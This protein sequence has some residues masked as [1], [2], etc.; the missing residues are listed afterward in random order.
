MRQQIHVYTED[1]GGSA[2]EV[3]ATIVEKTL[4]GISGD[5]R[6]VEPALSVERTTG[7]AQYAWG[8]QRWRTRKTM[9]PRR[10]L[11]R[12]L[13]NRVM[14]G[15]LI[16]LHID[17]DAP[18][19][20]PASPPDWGSLRDVE[21][22]LAQLSEWVGDEQRVKEAV[23]LLVPFAAIES[24][25]YL[26]QRPLAQLGLSDDLER[27]VCTWLR[28]QFSEDTGYD[29]VDKIKHR[30]R[31]SNNYNGDLSRSFP[32]KRALEHSPSYQQFFR[33]VEECSRLRLLLG[34]P[35]PEDG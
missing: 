22:L 19:S 34:L 31:L 4:N 5:W 9:G 10:E 29:H 11:I 27:N 1:T 17:S 13:A 18:W 7:Q 30:C 33:S 23:V 32:R 15:D 8:A 14:S 26:S 28:E 24:W 2:V 25:L 16:V 35:P 20:D 12:E 3:M 21:E 6:R